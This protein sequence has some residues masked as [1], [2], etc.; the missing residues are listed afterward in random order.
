MG[1]MKPKARQEFELFNVYYEDGSQTSNR[2]I[3]VSELDV[4]MD[5]DEQIEAIIAAQDVEIA[6]RSGRSRGPIASIEKVK[7]K[8]AD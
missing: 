6:E 8:K 2:K 5:R 3:L 7:M 1:R 4:L